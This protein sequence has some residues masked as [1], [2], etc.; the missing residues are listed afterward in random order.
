MRKV[1][2]KEETNDDDTFPTCLYDEKEPHDHNAQD[3]GLFRSEFLFKCFAHLYCG[4]GVARVG[5]N[6][7]NTRASKGDLYGMKS[8]TPETIAYAACQVRLATLFITVLTLPHMYYRAYTFCPLHHGGRC[9]VRGF[10]SK[11]CA[12]A[13]SNSS[14]K[15][16]HGQRR[17]SPGGTRKALFSHLKY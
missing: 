15:M 13:S 5:L 4:P 3:K 9:G 11:N 6:A 2:D 14:G 8:A 16:K 7:P 12:D 1:R 10:T 17:R